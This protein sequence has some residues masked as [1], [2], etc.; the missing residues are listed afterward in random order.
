M[1]TTTDI[2]A[3][4]TTADLEFSIAECEERLVKLQA[5]ASRFAQDWQDSHISNDGARVA[6]LSLRREQL[7][8]EIH[9]AKLTLGRLHASLHDLLRADVEAQVTNANAEY[10]NYQ[11]LCRDLEEEHKKHMAKMR[12]EGRPIIDAKIMADAAWEYWRSRSSAIASNIRNLIAQEQ[13][14][15][16]A[17]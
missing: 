15:N 2:A 13:R 10:E 17:R 9:A 5:E 14:L 3:Q 7:P 16:R 12:E 8:H 6:H 1:T 4:V 11:R